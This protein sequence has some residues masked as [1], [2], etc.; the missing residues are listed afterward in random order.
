M[1]DLTEKFVQSRKDKGEV[2]GGGL[3]IFRRGKKTGRIGIKRNAIAFEHGNL[4]S[5]QAEVD[6]LKELHPGEKFVIFMQ[7]ST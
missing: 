3:L 6:R 1:V 7:I 5:A 2:V 4:M